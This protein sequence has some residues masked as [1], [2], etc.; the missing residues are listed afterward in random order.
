MMAYLAA[1]RNMVADLWSPLSR[2]WQS[3]MRNHDHN[4]QDHTTENFRNAYSKI[5][6]M[7]IAQSFM[8]TNQRAKN[9]QHG[10][11]N[12]STN[13]LFCASFSQGTQAFAILIPA[14]RPA[15]KT[16]VAVTHAQASGKEYMRESF[17]RR[18]LSN[19]NEWN[20]N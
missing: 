5:Q 19:H 20:G 17:N 7:K 13:C 18:T 1:S 3:E 9:L 16:T 6:I 11:F 8:L 4:L 10:Q 15:V 14:P 12:A 2:F